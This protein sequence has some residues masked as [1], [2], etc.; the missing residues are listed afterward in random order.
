MR[1]PS[2]RGLSLIESSSVLVLDEIDSLITKDQEV[3]YRLFE[4]AVLPNSRLALIGIANALDLIDR[5]LPR[6][7]AKNCM[8]S[9]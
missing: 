9:T 7:K 5:F 1:V 2:Y 8:L 4:W 6:L 3:L